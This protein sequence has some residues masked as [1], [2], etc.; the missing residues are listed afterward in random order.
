MPPAPHALASPLLSQQET[1]GNS[2]LIISSLIQHPLQ[3]LLPLLHPI[4]IP[5]ASLGAKSKDAI[6]VIS[7]TPGG[8][9]ILFETL[10]VFRIS[11]SQPTLDSAS[12]PPAP[13]LLF[14]SSQH[15]L[16]DRPL[17]VPL[18]PSTAS[19]WSPKPSG[20]A[21]PRLLKQHILNTTL[22]ILGLQTSCVFQNGGWH[23]LPTRS[24]NQAPEP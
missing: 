13:P 24:Q 17:H 5:P 2:L 21:A 16:L 12:Q 18:S 7:L 1:P 20:L 19:A 10:S 11:A 4:W 3:F 23:P 8:G 14:C 9:S 22:I 15:S 6:T